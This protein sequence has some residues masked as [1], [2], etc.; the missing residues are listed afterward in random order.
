MS[1]VSN[2]IGEHRGRLALSAMSAT[3]LAGGL[4]AVQ[5]VLVG[6]AAAT[7]VIAWCLAVLPPLLLPIAVHSGVLSTSPIV[8]VIGPV[9]PT[10][11][12]IGFTS[13]L[14]FARS[15]RRLPP[16]LARLGLLAAAFVVYTAAGAMLGGGPG[17]TEKSLRL[18]LFIGWGF[19]LAWLIGMDRRATIV[20]LAFIVVGAMVIAV[21]SAGNWISTGTPFVFAENRIIFGRSVGV[22]AVVALGA[23][24]TGRLPRNLRVLSLMVGL[25]LAVVTIGSASR[26]A[27]ISLGAAGAVMLVLPV[28][29]RRIGTRALAVALLLGVGLLAVIASSGTF[30]F[31]R[32]QSLGNIGTDTTSLLRLQ[33]IEYSFR[34]WLSAPLFGVGLQNLQL[35]VAV[36]AF[37]D[38]LDYPH[39]MIIETL[40]QTGIVGLLL[41]AAILGLPVAA[42]LR[43]PQLR[44]DPVVAL[45]VGVLV[46]YF[47][48]AQFSGDL[49]INRYVWAFAFFL[50]A[51]PA[52]LRDRP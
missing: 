28:A 5:P 10:L 26:G 2:A 47:V 30:G 37:R 14:I 52:W 44:S 11:V 3:A 45:L 23:A 34:Q 4:I 32:L 33:A 21:A 17:S 19:L 41:M 38:I 13:V 8:E 15:S 27:F 36:G 25:A 31:E 42:V 43:K 22:G 6:G 39:N 35:D 24:L 50:G 49:Q 16:S 7:A 18:A 46:F 12:L 9:A 29:G 20:A 40:S 1:W 48:S 51:T